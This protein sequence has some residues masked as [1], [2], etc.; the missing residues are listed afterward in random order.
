M[1]D[2]V[3]ESYLYLKLGEDPGFSKSCAWSKLNEKDKKNSIRNYNAFQNDVKEIIE[4]VNTDGLRIKNKI[5]FDYAFFSE[6][7]KLRNK[8]SKEQA[9]IVKAIWSKVGIKPTNI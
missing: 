3:Y 5:E 8:S 2:F 7:G 9:S 4:Y 1:R 6:A